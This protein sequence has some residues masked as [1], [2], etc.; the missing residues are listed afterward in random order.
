MAVIS[1]FIGVLNNKNITNILL[2]CKQ[3]YSTF[4]TIAKELLD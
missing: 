4:P 3:D 2:P 1:L